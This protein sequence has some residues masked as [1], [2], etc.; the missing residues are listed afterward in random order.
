LS[1]KIT[2]YIAFRSRIAK[3]QKSDSIYIMVSQEMS[4]EGRARIWILL[5][6]AV[7]GMSI[8]TGFQLA[9]YWISASEM[10]DFLVEAT[11]TGEMTSDENLRSAVIQKANQMGIELSD[12]DIEIERSPKQLTISTAW[13]LDYNFFGFY[14]HTFTFS[15]HVTTHYQ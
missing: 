11:R 10:K 3:K 8:Y 15:P 4:S 9:P 7:I 12:R 5:I 1:R 6:L 2:P 13:Q 14:T